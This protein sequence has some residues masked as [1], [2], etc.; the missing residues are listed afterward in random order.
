MR[1]TTVI[2]KKDLHLEEDAPACIKV[3]S[4][5]LPHVNYPTSNVGAFIMPIQFTWFGG[6]HEAETRH[7]LRHATKMLYDYLRA[8]LGKADNGAPRLRG[9]GTYE[10]SNYMAMA[11]FMDSAKEDS[12]PTKQPQGR[13]GGVDETKAPSPK[14]RVA[15]GLAPPWHSASTTARQGTLSRRKSW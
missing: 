14:S 11:P 3:L 9:C 13:G 12:P 15:A 6:R 5:K 2:A 8:V 7:G 1:L 4:F 10:L